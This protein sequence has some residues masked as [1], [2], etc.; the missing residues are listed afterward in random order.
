MEAHALWRWPRRQTEACCPCREYGLLWG[1]WWRIRQFDLLKKILELTKDC[2]EDAEALEAAWEG[3]T[4]GV[5]AA[6]IEEALYV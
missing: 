1:A 2:R 3:E 6:L 4:E 5:S